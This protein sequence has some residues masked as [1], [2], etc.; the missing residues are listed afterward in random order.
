M[1]SPAVQ[2]GS[3]CPELPAA[4]STRSALDFVH[5]LLAGQAKNPP[6]PEQFLAG[7]TRAFR[8]TGAGL[9]GLRKNTAW[10][11]HRVSA[12]Q[13][14]LPPCRRP[15]E[16]Q[17][18]LL[19]QVR[20]NPTAVPVATASGL[21]CLLTA[22]CL[23]EGTGWLLWLEDTRGRDWG[24]DE[25]AALALAASV[26]GRWSAHESASSPWARWIKQARLQQGLEEAALV[27]GRLAHDFG[28]VFTGI[29]GF[30]ELSLGQLLC[31]S[32]VHQYATEIY[33][34]AQQ[35]ARLIQQLNLFSQR[36][37]S[38]PASTSLAAVLADEQ[39]RL[40]AAGGA[41]VPLKLLVPDDLAPVAVDS[42]SL[43]H[44]LS[45]L[46][47]N[48]REAITPTGAV[49]V[50]ARQTELQESD[51]LELLGNPTP[52]PCVEVTIADTGPGLSPEAQR[53]L[54]TEPFFSTKPRH[55]GLGLASVYGILQA[56]RGGFRLEHGR[57]K[58]TI[59]QVFL[60]L[61]AT[62][63]PRRPFRT[64]AGAGT[65]PK[66]LVVDDDPS[67][68]QL[69]CA[70]LE[71]AGYRVQAAVDGVQALDSYTTATEPFQL[72]LSDV[73]MPRMSGLD[74]ARQLVGRDPNVNVL[75]TSGQVPAESVGETMAGRNFDLLPKPFRPDGLLRAVETALD[76][77]PHGSPVRLGMRNAEK[78]L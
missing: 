59:V 45:Q 16:D 15:W 57:D 22:S 34:G 53:R 36:A 69:M 56:C 74:L 19:A 38:R 4:D 41:A 26:L 24:A 70:T 55:R 32:A 8:A 62:V 66:V 25:Q 6:A 67:A 58:G 76:R 39:A 33:Q 28:N 12:A 60:P 18:E 77:S 27:A 30:A 42:D 61:G 17:P 52:G 9:A 2:E 50:A 5:G 29:L 10:V 68:L 75:F 3:A 78:S 40:R 51:C 31:G 35:G 63:A 47:T 43:R 23:P 71:R 49:T 7:L 11:K 72:V 54:F 20:N 14:A 44:L 64:A 46:L 37:G 21:S 65:A 1:T 48:A 73:I 13:D